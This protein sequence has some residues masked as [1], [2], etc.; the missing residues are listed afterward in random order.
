MANTRGEGGKEH[1][2]KKKRV[3]GMTGVD[4]GVPEDP[5]K[6]SRGGLAVEKETENERKLYS[7]R[8]GIWR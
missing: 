7:L 5:T 6:E 1:E 4:K 8:I 3:Q 2:G